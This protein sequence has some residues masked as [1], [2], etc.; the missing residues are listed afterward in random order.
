M[1]AIRVEQFGGP[2]VMRIT[3]IRDPQPA[4]DQVL[5][6]LRA[7]GVNPVDTYVRA[8][9]YARKPDLPYTPGTD[10]AGE[11]ESVGEKVTEFKTGDRVYLSGALTG[12]YAEKALCEISDVHAL[13]KN[14]SFAQGAA[15]GVP[16][17]TAYR[18]L[19]FRGEARPGETVLI[20]GATGGV[21]T[22]AVQLARASGLRVLGTGG[23]EAGRKL[24]REQGAVDVFDHHAPNYCDEIL[25]AT[26]GLGVNLILEMLANV[27]LGKDLSLLAK[28]GRVVVI[29]SRGKTEIDPRAAMSRDADIRGMVLF[30]ASP[31]ERASIY[32]G[33]TASLESGALR[34]II[35]REFPLSE[36]PAAH[37]ALMESGAFG[38]VILLPD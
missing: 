21:G 36:A 25:E 2:E 13:P 4:A 31:S 38:K 24:V 32:A 22:A 10:A 23:T 18:A 3:E 19:F 30:N 9:T 27:N 34:P 5:V 8:G 12:S 16:S 37:R 17:A 33:L 15:V 35:G 20:H 14:V 28:N 7:I 11:I 6:R 29:G 1:K 26:N